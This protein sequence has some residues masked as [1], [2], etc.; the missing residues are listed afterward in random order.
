MPSPQDISRQFSLQ[1][2]RYGSVSSIQEV[3]AKRLWTAIQNTSSLPLPRI[4]DIGAGT[5]HLSLLLAEA[6]PQEQHLLD[7]S[8]AMLHQA[9]LRLHQSFPSLKIVAHIGDAEEWSPQ[10]HSFDLIASNAAVQWFK[11][12]PQFC[13]NVRHG[14]KTQGIL[15]IGT[16][17]KHSL[18]ELYKAYRITTGNDLQAG[19]HMFASEELHES[20]RAAGFDVLTESKEKICSYHESPRDILRDLKKMGVTGGNRANP[21]NRKQVL[22]LETNLENACRYENG[23]YALTWE[24]V[25]L[26]ART[27]SK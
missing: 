18:V 26:V 24:L 11:D 22:Q 27:L 17:G 20:V 8:D 4:A 2:D 19:T 25:W 15:A 9:C 3:L 21:L 13:K 12:F 7:L 1:A 14:L 23:R 5:G 6:N 16:F 10:P